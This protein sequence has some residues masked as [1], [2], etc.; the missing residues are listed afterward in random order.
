[1]LK[2]CGTENGRIFLCGQDGCLY[3]LTYEAEEGWFRKKC[4]KLNHTQSIIGLLVPNFMKFTTNQPIIDITVD[5]ERNVL[6][7]LSEDS[8]ID[9]YDLGEH[10]N[11]MLKVATLQ[12]ETLLRGVPLMQTLPQIV[13]ISPIGTKESRQV[14][15]VAI[16]TSGDRYYFSI[17]AS[18]SSRRPNSLVCVAMKALPDSVRYG[19]YGT[20]VSGSNLGQNTENILVQ[21][22]FFDKGVFVMADARLEGMDTL[23]CIALETMAARNQTSSPSDTF[24]RNRLSEMI[25]KID[26]Q[27]KTLAIGEVQMEEEPSIADIAPFNELARQYLSPSREF[28]CLSNNGIVFMRKFRPV[29]TLQQL[30][31]QNDSESIRTFVTKYGADE[32]CAMFLMI[33]CS[34]PN[35][36]TLPFGQYHHAGVSTVENYFFEFGGTPSRELSIGRT[37]PSSF[38]GPV[39]IP[40]VY[41]SPMHNAFYLLFA[42]LIRPFWRSPIFVSVSSSKDGACDTQVSTLFSSD[43]FRE[44]ETTLLG[45]KSFFERHPHTFTPYLRPDSAS[46]ALHMHDGRD[47]S[48]G[49]TA[50]TENSVQTQQHELFGLYH[51]NSRSLQVLAF[52]EI[53]KQC[54]LQVLLRPQWVPED[55]QRRLLQLKFKDFATQQEGEELMKD[56][57]R[58]IVDKGSLR[59][60]ERLTENLEVKCSSFFNRKDILE[61]K[62]FDLLQQAQKNFETNNI[63]ISEELADKSLR[64]YS[65]IADSIRVD[66]VCRPFQ[67][68]QYYTGCVDLALTAAK[69]KDPNNLALDWTRNGRPAH[70]IDGSKAFQ[71]RKRCYESALAV[72]E[73]LDMPPI[74]QVSSSLL[75]LSNRGLHAASGASSST[76]QQVR[77]AS[78]LPKSERERMRTEVITRMLKSD[79]ELFYDALFTWMK[80]HHREAE[81]LE[82]N[83][84]FLES[85]LQRENDYN[86]LWQYYEKREKYDKAAKV[87]VKLAEMESSSTSIETRIHSLSKAVINARLAAVP[88]SLLKVLEDKLEV[89]R[90]QGRVLSEMH[91]MMKDPNVPD[92]RK[93]A[94]APASAELNRK[95]IAPEQLY[96]DYAH[97]FKLYE[98]CLI[99]LHCTGYKDVT[100]IQKL[101]KKVISRNSTSQDRLARK[102]RE[103]GY[104][105]YDADSVFFPLDY[106][107]AT[108][109][110][111]NFEDGQTRND[112]TWIIRMM[113]EVGVPFSTLY[114]AYYRLYLYL[115]EN[116]LG[117]P[118]EHMAREQFIAPAS[119]TTSNEVLDQ[120]FGP[121]IEDVLKFNIL[122]ALTQLL[123]M[124][125]SHIQSPLATW[126]ETQEFPEE[127]LRSH[128]TDID[129]LLNMFVRK[130][131]RVLEMRRILRKFMSDR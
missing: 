79:D 86:L 8:L 131:S 61:I 119:V 110:R 123:D 55:R 84:S 111:Y 18:P 54:N 34:V 71:T 39:S 89:A 94:L 42:R 48:A 82:M 69:A 120:V 19:A 59:N 35:T 78:V 100:L 121:S 38:G 76:T 122:C 50:F 113:R 127:L 29:D 28:V 45:L 73:E 58:L 80:Y 72:L 118:Q 68:M 129:S 10:G 126:A 9:V 33:A 103:L 104:Q 64:L 109:E 21:E 2:I 4:R 27:G 56:L 91:Q 43:F 13:Y 11:S 108:L 17:F 63:E 92:A 74:Q 31:Q 40:D 46:R 1:M 106:L 114:F 107:I 62:A 60:V 14:Q 88:G 125:F 52:I 97:R 75:G 105:L 81:L 3:E 26:V 99:I 96:N 102:L 93:D 47:P 7:T 77:H 44:V 16:S 36:T 12:R 53:L 90:A 15:L 85:Y 98:S 115:F 49:G 95:L 6:Y 70:D 67:K 25:S 101:W 30:L 20:S 83:T 24:A 87:L 51:L 57:V 124:W 128:M 65:K 117:S 22:A 66:L 37:E 112:S 130:D 32:A 116:H 5:R 41:F 23:Y